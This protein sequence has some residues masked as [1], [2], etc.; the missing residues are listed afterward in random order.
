VKRNPL[1]TALVALVVLSLVG[2]ACGI[3]V[4]YLDAREQ[5]GIARRAQTFAEQQRTKA[6]AERDR[7]EVLAYSS[8]IAL[9]QR[10][11]QEGD[12]GLAWHHL[13]SC[14]WNLRGW[15]HNYLYTQF[16]K[17]QRPLKERISLQ[18]HTNIVLCVA[19]SSDGERIVSGGED[20]TLKIWDSSTGTE[21]R[22][23]KG[24]TG[25]VYCVAFSPDGKHIV[26]GGEGEK[27]FGPG[28]LKVW[29][30]DKGVEVLSLKVHTNDVWGVAYS[31]DGKHIVTASADGTLIVWDASTGAEILSFKGHSPSSP[32]F[33]QCV[34]Y[35]PDGKRIV[36]G[37][38]NGLLKVWD[39]A[40][41]AEVRS[42]HAHHKQVNYVAYSPDGKRIVSGSGDRGYRGP[43]TLQRVPGPRM[44]GDL[45]VWD[46]DTGAEIL[47]LKGH[48]LRVSSVAYS[49]DGKRIV[50]G[51]WDETVKV[52][53]ADTGT[54]TLTFK[55]HT[56]KVSAVAFS[57]DG[58]RMVSGSWDKTLKVWDADKRA[59]VFSLEAHVDPVSSVAYSPDGKRI[60]STSGA[61]EQGG[62]SGEVMVWDAASG[63]EIL[64]HKLL[65]P[66]G[67]EVPVYCV[68]Y[69]PDSKRLVCASDDFTLKV[70]DADTGA[71][72]LS[73]K[74]HAGPPTCVA[75]SLDGKRIVSGNS[76]E[77]KV[78]NAQ[79]GTEILSL[80]SLKRGGKFHGFRFSCVAFSPDGT[81]I[82][83]THQNDA[84][85]V[86]DANTGTEVRTLTGHTGDVTSVAYRPDGK[87][88]A[89]ASED[90]TLK[91]WDVDTGTEVQTLTGHTDAVTSVA[92]SPDATRIVSGSADQTL[93]VWDAEKGIETLSLQGHTDWVTSVAYSPDGKRIISGSHD[94]TVKVWDV[95]AP[96]QQRVIVWWGGVR[97]LAARLVESLFAKPLLRSEV[98]AAI[99]ADAALSEEVRQEALT[100]A[101]TFPENANVLNHASW[102]VVRQP[103]ADAAAYQRALRQ[104]EAACRLAPD[105]AAFRN[106]LGVAYYRVGKYPEAIEALEKNLPEKAS[107][108]VDASDLYFLAMCHYRL[109]NAAKARE[110]FERAKDSHQRNAVRLP[111]E[112]LGELKQFRTEAE[113]LLAKPAENR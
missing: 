4:K 106:T 55:G 47:S 49:P 16:T 104:A 22:T 3:F 70:L 31:P 44:A 96:S 83:S 27:A 71:E 90:Q 19:Y 110:C 33:V 63:L 28:E 103:G 17:N 61:K 45:K 21:I 15:E 75:Y 94:G 107:N 9:A 52:W 60:V 81:R 46:A 98:L 65:N 5:E 85:K 113:T 24:H 87:R 91:V 35:S 2:G 68:A 108:R 53:D 32:T 57:P 93:K 66:N 30:A 64:T 69:S 41:G 79:K 74:G 29:D 11:W 88:I 8:R 105:V 95:T 48:T 80:K 76:A 109:G 43:Q 18:G 37:D 100:M 59:K 38:V 86:W 73:L 92:Y 82:V 42:I 58:K 26:S 101:D 72:V 102:A 39:A 20:K 40:T 10:D 67:Y 6:F 12:P 111:K 62:R 112:Q 51:S 84:L 99:R 56:N 50:S 13:E 36:S 7:A 14:P 77:L 34:A 89:S 54:E 25:V 1:V 23:L 97:Y 78:W